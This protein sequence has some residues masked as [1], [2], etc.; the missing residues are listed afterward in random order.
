MDTLPKFDWYYQAGQLEQKHADLQ[1]MLAVPE[2][3]TT[4]AVPVDLCNLI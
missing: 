1:E 4:I 3:T 2:I